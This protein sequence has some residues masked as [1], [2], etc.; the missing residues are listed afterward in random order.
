MIDFHFSNY[1]IFIHPNYNLERIEGIKAES[2]V[3]LVVLVR[4]VQI[5]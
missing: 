5:K 1:S 2:L 4:S 3:E